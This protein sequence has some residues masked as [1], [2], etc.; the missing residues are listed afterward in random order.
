M[1][2]PNLLETRIGRLTAFFFL[3]MT[4]GIP[5]GFTSIAVATQMRREGVGP[6]AIGSFVATLYIPWAW[7]WMIGPVVDVFYCDRLG[8]RRLWIVV[9]QVMMATALMAAMPVNFSTQIKLFTVLI[10]I[11]NIFAATQDVAVDALA[12]GVLKEDERGLANGLMFGGSYLGTAVGGAGVLFLT[13]Y[14]GF[15]GTFFFVAGCILAITTFVAV[16]LR[17]PRSKAPSDSF[18][19]LSLLNT[20]L[21][22][23]GYVWTV[24]PAIFGSR[25]AVV[26]LVFALM[27]MG[28]YALGLA[29]QANLAVELG[30]SD[31][32]IAVLSLLSTIISAAGCIVGGF[33]SDKFGRKRMLALYLA[34]TAIPTVALAIL[35]YHH[36]W[37]MSVDPRMPNRPVPPDALVVG[38]WAATLIYSV[39]Q[40]LMYGTRTALF[41]DITNPKVAATQFTAYMALLNLVIAYSALWQGQAIE[42]WGYPAT[43]LIDAA[44]G[45]L[46]IAL[47]PLMTRPSSSENSSLE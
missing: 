27:P 21:D 5:F 19:G 22:I 31:G 24:F 12:C 25:A 28:A 42:A 14:V 40:G 34:A 38:F 1:K 10:F 8:R 37:I 29:L 3:Y 23:R 44:V 26:G 6:A 18:N 45:L 43:L 41:M 20:L 13:S 30:L 7:K 9:A 17:E 11:H 36:G 35:M 15:N 16:P 33:L 2:L 32:R 4:Q 47:L 46:C 39:P